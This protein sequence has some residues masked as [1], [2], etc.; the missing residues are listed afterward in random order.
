ML[1]NQSYQYLF[2]KATLF[3]CFLL[4]S[5]CNGSGASGNN[6]TNSSNS[7][8]IGKSNVNSNEEPRW[9]YVESIARAKK[10]TQENHADSTH[11]RMFLSTAY[12]GN[13]V[14]AA[15]NAIVAAKDESTVVT[16]G[17]AAD[18]LTAGYD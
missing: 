4:L 18:Y 11:Y 5:A 15:T 17:I 13:L 7:A 10:S 8:S 6:G 2:S 14:A 9:R 12:N 3:C 16:N 1:Y